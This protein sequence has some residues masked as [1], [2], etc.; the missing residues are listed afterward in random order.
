MQPI[1]TLHIIMPVKDSI[2]TTCEAIQALYASDNRHWTLTVYNDFSTPENTTRLTQLSRQYAFTLFNWADH[3]N[4]PS[5]NYRLTLIQA[6]HRALVDHAHLL[7]IESDVLVQEDTI[8]CILGEVM[9]G[10]GMVAAVT[11][12]DEGRINFPYEYAR[13]LKEDG[14]TDKRLSFCCTLLTNELLRAIDFHKLDAGKS[15]YDVYIS[16]LSHRMGYTNLLLLSAPVTHHP[17]SSRPWKLLKYKN[18][19][20]YYWRKWTQAKDRI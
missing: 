13:R 12:D 11:H 2:E 20:L 6:Q 4:H 9:G 1:D 8:D 16:H 17:H 3:T 19:I 14:P 5:P 7:I 15:W 10:V 18:P